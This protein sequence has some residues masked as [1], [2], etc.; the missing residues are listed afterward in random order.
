MLQR[1]ELPSERDNEHE[2]PRSARR[3]QVTQVTK[4]GSGLTC[5]VRM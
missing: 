4:A 2:S 3:A 1:E 5:L